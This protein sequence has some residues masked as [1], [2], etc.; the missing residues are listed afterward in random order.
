MKELSQ[1]F[2]RLLDSYHDNKV[3]GGGVQLFILTG[4]RWL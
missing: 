1:H 4:N 2:I 3:S